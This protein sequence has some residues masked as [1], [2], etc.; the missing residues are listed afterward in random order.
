M[1]GE[2]ALRETA[3]SERLLLLTLGGETPGTSYGANCLA[4]AGGEATLL[5]DPLIA[6]AHARL[7]EE[8]VARRGFPPV[9]QVVVTHHHTDHALGAGWFASRGARVVAHGRC[10]PLMAAQHPAMVRERRRQ[11]DL[12][13]L[14]A[15]AEPHL[16]A[17]TFEDRLTLDLGGAAVEVLHLGPGH[18]P[19]DAVVWLPSEG[20][21]ATGDHLFSGYHFNYEEADRGLLSA[22]DRL[23][24]LPARRLV[25]GHGP[26]GGPERIAEQRRYHETARRLVAAAPDA[27]AAGRALLAAFPEYLLP[28][29]V[30]TAWPFW[31]SP[32]PRSP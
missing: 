25:P 13:A 27:E 32:E 1:A 8:A 4:F 11:P 15:D 20:T 2:V 16:P 26:A 3:L 9:R 31:R 18:S 21:A 6:P 12:A 29:A 24:A 10:A 28:V 19:G 14:F 5:V 30:G 17:V 22:L 23:E 7:V